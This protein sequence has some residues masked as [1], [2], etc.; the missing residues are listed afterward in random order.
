[1]DIL[2]YS[3]RG[4]STLP[5][6]MFEFQDCLSFDKV[7]NASCLAASASLSSGTMSES[8]SSLTSAF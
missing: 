8:K 5:D 4:L 2:L 6:G 3:W 7:A 1:M